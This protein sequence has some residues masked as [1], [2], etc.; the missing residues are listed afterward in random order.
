MIDSFPEGQ[1]ADRSQSREDNEV[2][3][4]PSRSTS[5]A[6]PAPLGVQGHLPTLTPAAVGEGALS[7]GR[8]SWRASLLGDF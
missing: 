5:G 3:T 8:K 1:A 4:G 2:K 6:L 7:A